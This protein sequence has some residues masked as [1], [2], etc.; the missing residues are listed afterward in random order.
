MTTPVVH[1]YQ[2]TANA[3]KNSTFHVR[4]S[5][6]SLKCMDSACVC[7]SKVTTTVTILGELSRQ[8]LFETGKQAEVLFAADTM[9]FLE[10]AGTC[11]LT[12]LRTFWEGSLVIDYTT[13][14]ETALAAGTKG[15]G[16][17]RDRARGEGTRGGCT[18]ME[19]Y[20]P[21]LSAEQTTDKTETYVNSEVK[22]SCVTPY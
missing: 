5:P 11:V 15:K 9:T 13:A 2:G 18:I 21:F 4:L 20:W 16:V 6:A 8:L 7:G 10:D 19:H 14:D 12:V 1:S 3:T 17:G 22:L